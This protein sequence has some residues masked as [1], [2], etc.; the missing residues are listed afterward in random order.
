MERNSV[1]LS[2]KIERLER[3]EGK[4]KQ[5][6]I[7]SQSKIPTWEGIKL[8]PLTTPRPWFSDCLLFLNYDIFFEEGLFSKTNPCQIKSF[9]Y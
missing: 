5:G 7:T 4:F 2:S 8:G 3:H 1:N 9:G 6:D